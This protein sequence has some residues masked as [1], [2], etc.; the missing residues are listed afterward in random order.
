MTSAATDIRFHLDPPGPGT[1]TIDAVHF[2]RPVTRYWAEMHP[3]ALRRGFSEFTRHYGMLIDTLELAYPEGFAYS[4]IVPA[5]ESEI[6][7][8][9]Q[10]AEEVFEHKLWREQLREWDATFK[11]A[12]IRKHLELTHV[13]LAPKHGLGPRAG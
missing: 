8:R 3:D 4:S 2:P 7:A 5:P 13:A 10:R 9:F 12:A 11:P 1:W 6:P